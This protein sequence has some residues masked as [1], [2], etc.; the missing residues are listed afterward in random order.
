[1][2]LAAGFRAF[3]QI[4]QPDFFVVLRLIH[5]GFLL[6]PFQFIAHQSTCLS[7]GTVTALCSAPRAALHTVQ[8][9][10]SRQML[11][12]KIVL[13]ICGV[14]NEILNKTGNEGLKNSTPST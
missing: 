3:P 8:E 13:R 12:T 5:D 9:N 6:N 1:M 2:T 7:Q 11:F 14:L 4:T 10:D